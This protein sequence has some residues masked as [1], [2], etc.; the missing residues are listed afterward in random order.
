LLKV[1]GCSRCAQQGIK[2]SGT[3]KVKEFFAT[4]TMR[5]SDEYVPNSH[6]AGGFSIIA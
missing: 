4:T 2:P 3:F 6:S 1:I 5:I